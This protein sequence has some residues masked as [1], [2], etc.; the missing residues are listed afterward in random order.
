MQ[1][2]ASDG[3]GFPQDGQRRSSACPHDMQN[4][5]S[6]GFALPQLSHVLSIP[7]PDEQVYGWAPPGSG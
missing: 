1:N 6:D 2:F 3:A 5:A 4:F 7:N